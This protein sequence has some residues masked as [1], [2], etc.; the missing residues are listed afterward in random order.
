MAQTMELGELP[1]AV[2]KQLQVAITKVLADTKHVSFEDL[3]AVDKLTA[4]NQMLQ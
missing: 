2:L 4:I 1:I 3:Q